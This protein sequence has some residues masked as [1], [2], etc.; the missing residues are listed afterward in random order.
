MGR[1]GQPAPVPAP[2]S[3]TPPSLPTACDP[4]ALATT[5]A[6]AIVAPPTMAAIIAPAKLSPAP[7]RSLTVTWP[8][9]RDISVTT[10]SRPATSGPAAPRV[11]TRSVSHEAAVAV[12]VQHDGDARGRA[13]DSHRRGQ[14][15]SC[16]GAVLGDHLRAQIVAEHGAQPSPRSGRGRNRGAGDRAAA[17]DRELVGEDLLAWPRQPVQLPEDQLEEDQ[18]ERD[19]VHRAASRCAPLSGRGPGA[20]RSPPARFARHITVRP[21]TL[22]RP[23]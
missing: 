2:T 22:L 4:A 3:P 16:R 13:G 6:S 18:P 19:H 23:G 17:G 14:V 11:T 7:V 20:G 15:H 5:A 8:T 1:N 9:P 21:R 10:R 12:E